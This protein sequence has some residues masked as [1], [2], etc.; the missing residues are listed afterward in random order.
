M[1]T[2]GVGKTHLATAVGIESAKNRFQTYFITANDL[3]AQ[4]KKA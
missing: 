4:L 1:G 3:I 2:S